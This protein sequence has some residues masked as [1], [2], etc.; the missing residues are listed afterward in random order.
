MASQSPKRDEAWVKDEI[1]KRLKLFD[2]MHVWMPSA[3]Q[4]GVS[5]QHD[6]MICQR[7]F[8]WTIE[9]KAAKASKPYPTALQIKFAND[10]ERAKGISI[11]VNEFRLNKIIPIATYIEVYGRLP[12]DLRDD[13][14]QW[15]K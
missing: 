2:A 15:S 6:F 14:N 8:L 7:G 9:A 11:M 10:I 1:K 4:F 5:G 12:Y 13:F 3:S